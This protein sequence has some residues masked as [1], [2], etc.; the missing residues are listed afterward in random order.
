MDQQNHLLASYTAGTNSPNFHVHRL[1]P[2]KAQEELHRHDFFQIILLEEGHIRQSIDFTEYDM[3][4]RSV[5]VVF[6]RQLHQL[7]LSDDARGWIVM[8][9]STVFCT[10]MLRNELKDYNIDLQQ[11]INFLAF[12]QS[13]EIFR[14]LLEL[15]DHIRQTSTA[16]NPIRK[17]QVKLTI[18]IM[19][20]K[21]IDFHPNALSQTISDSETSLY[22]RF[23]EQVDEHYQRQR[24]VNVYADH[25]GLT[26][27][28]L[29]AIC[30]HYSGLSPLEIIH[31]KLSL[32]LKK[33]L[34]LDHLTFK[35][36]A[37]EYGFSS[38][39]ALNK[40]IEQKFGMTPLAL[41]NKLKQSTLQP[42]QPTVTIL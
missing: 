31:E 34:A 14:E 5:S 18:K 1:L 40:Y 8:F 35:E 6:P 16:L 20:L 32:E 42:Q 39:S 7:Q 2:S 3:N 11:K 19:L 22:I 24:K 29:T 37:F 15:V 17:M 38:Q 9:D 4:A 25:L 33:V 13:P 26:V 36:I 30:R 21:I 10:E 27:K 41:K 28:K 12:G 23:R